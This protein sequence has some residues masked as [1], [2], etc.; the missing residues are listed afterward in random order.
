MMCAT[1]CIALIVETIKWDAKLSAY[2]NSIERTVKAQA[3]LL[4]QV[5]ITSTRLAETIT[6]ANNIATTLDGSLTKDTVREYNNY[7]RAQ[8]FALINGSK[9]GDKLLQEGAAT[10]KALHAKID[11]V[12]VVGIQA[13]I[14]KAVNTVNAQV[15]ANGQAL[16]CLTNRGE[17]LIEATQPQLLALMAELTKS[18]ASLTTITSN[19][20]IARLLGNV[21]DDTHSLNVI[22]D[23]FGTLAHKY[24][25]PEPVKGFFPKLLAAGKYAVRLIAGASSLI[26]F[27]DKL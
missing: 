19:P 7:L 27:V 21:A 15:D 18:I 6:H 8:E 9:S 13:S 25:Y 1:L 11:A 17:T 3:P 14:I 4:A 23:A 22:L 20:D 10:I 12:D 24:A 5:N 2:S 16:T 26:V